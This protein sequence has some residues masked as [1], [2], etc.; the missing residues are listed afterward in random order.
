M[1]SFR[2]AE[3]VL[4]GHPPREPR[5]RGSGGLGPGGAGGGPEGL[6]GFWRRHTH[7]HRRGSWAGMAEGPSTM[8]RWLSNSKP[9]LWPEDPATPQPLLWGTQR[10][11]PASSQPS[12]PPATHPSS[13]LL[14][15]TGLPSQ[16]APPRLWAPV[17]AAPLPFS[18]LRPCSCRRPSLAVHS[19]DACGGVPY[20]PHL[21]NI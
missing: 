15:C 3:P 20:I 18:Q 14:E 10:S 12:R 1:P 6:K 11:R 7:G 5:G 8:S 2:S 4:L 19:Q 16:A 9:P 13:R 21:C 17:L